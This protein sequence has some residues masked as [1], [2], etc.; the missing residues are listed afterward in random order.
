MDLKNLNLNDIKLDDI[1]S[2]LVALSGDK[3]T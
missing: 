2:K 1:K 3:K